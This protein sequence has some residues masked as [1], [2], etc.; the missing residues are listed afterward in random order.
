MDDLEL[1]K[2]RLVETNIIHGPTGSA[3]SYISESEIPRPVRP[4][5][6]WWQFHEL[7]PISRAFQ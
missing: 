4:Q 3:I 5:H 7:Q 6:P 1:Q 2:A